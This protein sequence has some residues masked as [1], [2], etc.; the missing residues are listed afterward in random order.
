MGVQ[1]IE[2]NCITNDI[3]EED[4]RTV[5]LT[6]IS[7]TADF[8][9]GVENS[10]STFTVTLGNSEVSNGY[11]AFVE[12][13]GSIEEGKDLQIPVVMVAVAAE[14]VRLLVRQRGDGHRLAGRVVAD[15]IRPRA[16]ARRSRHRRL[17]R[18]LCFAGDARELRLGHDDP[19][20]PALR[21]R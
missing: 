18:R 16:A 1:N 4:V 19:D 15:G 21:R 20:L 6:L 8:N 2:L 3:V 14:D 12:E 9:I 13:A 11:V 5:K 17:H 10:S 7:N